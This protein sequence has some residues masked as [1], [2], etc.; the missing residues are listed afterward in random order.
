MTMYAGGL[1]R[2]GPTSVV[3]T[4]R[5]SCGYAFGVPPRIWG[6][7]VPNAAHPMTRTGS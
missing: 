5:R 4:P 6:R 7:G 2:H 3:G 1:G